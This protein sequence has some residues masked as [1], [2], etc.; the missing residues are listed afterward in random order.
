MRC[1]FCGREMKKIVTPFK[2]PVKGEWLVVKDVEVYH[3]PGCG[4]VFFPNE[5]IKHAGRRVGERLLEV[6]KERGQIND[7]KEYKRNLVEQKKK[8]L[9]DAIRRGEIKKKP[10]APL[11][12]FT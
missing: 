8:D 11:K 10:N 4:A 5:T 6:A 2:R 3:C 7:V 9:E 12:V 1:K